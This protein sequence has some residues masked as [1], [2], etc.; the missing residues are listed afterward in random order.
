MSCRHKLLCRA[1]LDVEIGVAPAYHTRTRDNIHIRPSIRT[2]Q[3]AYQVLRLPTLT[4][5]TCET[6]FQILNRTVWMNNKAFKYRMRPDPNCDRR[7]EVETMEHLLCECM[8]YSQ[9][10]WDRL[11]EVIRVA[12][13]PW[14]R[15]F[16]RNVAVENF[17]W[18]WQIGGREW[19]W[20]G[21]EGVKNAQMWP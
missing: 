8:H 16:S 17:S 2:F 10:L 9:L 7:W 6:A 20:S 21:R 13:W 12:R 1:M 4:S 3:Y 14:R 11:G 19:P 15:P 18:P 5:K